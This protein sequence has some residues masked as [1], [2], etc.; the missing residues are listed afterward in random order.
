MEEEQKK[1]KKKRRWIIVYI[2]SGGILKE[3]FFMKYSQMILLV[4][5]LF[6]FFIGNRFTCLL[7][8]REINQ[9]QKEL[10]DV[11]AESISISEKL[12]GSNRLSQIEQMV[13]AEGLKLESAKTPLYILHK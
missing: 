6:I 3:G 8:V 5:A 1:E 13:A 11:K 4:V 12:I 10:A 2:L 7:K 9:L